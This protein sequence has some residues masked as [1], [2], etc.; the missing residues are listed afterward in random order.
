MMTGHFEKWYLYVNLLCELR[1]VI[2]WA[3][4]LAFY[5]VVMKCNNL[6][7]INIKFNTFSLKNKKNAWSCGDIG[8]PKSHLEN[9]T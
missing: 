3:R 8:Y 5:N 2:K 4:K 7:A 6:K 1:K 9:K